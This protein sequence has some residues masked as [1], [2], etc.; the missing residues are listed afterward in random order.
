MGQK[1][2]GMRLLIVGVL[3]C[4][5]IMATEER[6]MARPGHRGFGHRNFHSHFHSHSFLG[7]SFYGYPYSRYY[8]SLYYYTYKPGEHRRF[9]A[10]RL[11]GFFHY[12]GAVGKGEEGKQTFWPGAPGLGVQVHR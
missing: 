2:H 3:A 6:A 10:F 1:M 4:G 11:P 12:P 7:F 9:P 5:W 8:D